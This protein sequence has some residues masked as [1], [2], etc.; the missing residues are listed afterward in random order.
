M[1][2]VRKIV[3]VGLEA[4]SKANI[5]VRQPL[6]KLKVKSEK[7]KAEDLKPY[8]GL[9]KDEINVKE[10]IFDNTITEAV[11]LDINITSEL[12][13]EGNIRELI[14]GVQELRKQEKLSPSDKVSLKVKT[15]GKGRELIQKFEVEIKKTTLLK[16][17]SFEEFD[18]GTV[19]KVEE[20][21]FELK[22]TR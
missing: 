6:N 15:E 2:E 16:S 1:E 20:M 14:R 17:I 10:V 21:S 11:E 3:S 12:K 4:R 5:K 19:V 22:I 13:E 18:G 9:I 8:L 7:L